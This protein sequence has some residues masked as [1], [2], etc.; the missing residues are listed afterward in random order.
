MQK[1]FYIL[2][3]LTAVVITTVV[4]ANFSLA[5]RDH[6]RANFN[7]ARQAAM[8][9]IMTN[10]D[11]TA[12]QELVANKGQSKDLT[13]A[14]FNKLTDAW[15]A[16]QAGDYATAKQLRQ[17]LGLGKGLGLGFGRGWQTNDD[18]ST[19]GCQQSGCGRHFVDADNNGICDYRQ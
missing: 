14:D 17:E 2:A 19:K 4:V 11:F 7:S 8:T 13:Q 9:E 18:R 1:S 16:A 12:W 6:Y 5:Q 3:V 15:Q 10:K